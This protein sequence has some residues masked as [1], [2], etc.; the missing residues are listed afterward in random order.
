LDARRAACF[1]A[2]NRE[3]EQMIAVGHVVAVRAAPEKL[4]DIEMLQLDPGALFAVAREERR[5]DIIARVKGFE[6]TAHT[7]QYA[8][9]WSWLAQGIRES[10]KITI[11]EPL[12]II[13]RHID[14]GSRRGVGQN[15]LVRAA[16]HLNAIEGPSDTEYIF[17][18]PVHRA[19][20]RAARANER[21]IDV[22]ENNRHSA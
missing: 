6:Q 7:W 17:E 1:S 10:R 11:L 20:A 16:G 14:A 18:R 19:A 15:P 3:V 21:S 2:L 9:S 12:K 5:K 22:E 4:P 13:T 8:L